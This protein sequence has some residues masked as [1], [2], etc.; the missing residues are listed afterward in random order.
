MRYFAQAIDLKDDPSRIEEYIRHHRAVWPEVTEGLRA[1]GVCGMRIFRGGTRLFMV[2]ETVDGFDP[3]RDYQTYARDPRAR[4]WDELM[5]TFQQPVP[6][7]RPGEWWSQLDEI[8]D[9]GW[10]PEG[11]GRRNP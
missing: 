1:V 4:Q 6:S 10:F 5:R 11:R 3:G 8:F 7:A 9:L 2:I